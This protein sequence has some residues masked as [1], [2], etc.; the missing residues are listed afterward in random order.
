[1]V[2][3]GSYPAFNAYPAILAD[4]ATGNPV[5]VKPHPRA[6]LPMA[7]SVQIARGVLAEAG[8]DP[9]LITL[10]VDAPD[11]PLAKALATHHHT[12]IID[13]T[14]SPRFGA[15]LE[16]NVGRRQLYTETAGCNSVIFDSAPDPAAAIDAIAHGLCLFSGQMC[17]SPQNIY[18][19]RS[20]AAWATEALIAAVDRW[21]AEPGVCGALF[22]PRVEATVA[23]ATARGRVLRPSGRCIH[24]D[25]PR[26][27]TATPVIL[28]TDATDRA[29]TMEHFGPVA[30]L[31]T[32]DDGEQALAIAAA[33]ARDH[34]AIAS[35][36]YTTDPALQ[37]R[38][39]DAFAEAGA[40]LGIN[41]VHQRPIQFAGAFS[42]FHVT[43]LNPA[44]NATLT[45]PA[46]VA[47]R[48]RV[49]QTKIEETP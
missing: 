3:C 17:T 27:R 9:N 19:P 26:A 45:D 24:P 20:Q 35:Y 32:V 31:V 43:G 15:W 8:Y 36:L 4:L 38:A 23:A 29:L 28:G 39:A 34:G 16:A 14:G 44:G 13:F 12:R 41:L 21:S 33:H 1:M 6:I 2:C 40:S 18:L 42:D 25:H 37:Q 11:R 22:D 47:R 5:V 30:H 7:L 46:F 49:V 48:F 10:A